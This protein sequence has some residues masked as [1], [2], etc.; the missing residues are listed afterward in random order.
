MLPGAKWFHDPQLVHKIA[1]L[2]ER[3]QSPADRQAEREQSVLDSDNRL[4]PAETSRGRQMDGW[5]EFTPTGSD[6]SFIGRP[7]AAAAYA[8]GY[9]DAK[10]DNRDEAN[11]N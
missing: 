6:S 10:G 11:A 7:E 5:W 4:S 8:H 9:D 2:K 3:Q 1:K